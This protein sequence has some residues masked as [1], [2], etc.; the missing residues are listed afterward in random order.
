MKTFTAQ[1]G[2]E[3]S[4]VVTDSGVT[5]QMDTS[6]PVAALEG[7]RAHLLQRMENDAHVQHAEDISEIERLS[8]T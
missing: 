7:W 8:R 5:G 2:R 3:V 1:N 4:E 6:I